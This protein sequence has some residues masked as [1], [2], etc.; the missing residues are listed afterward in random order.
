MMNNNRKYAYFTLNYKRQEV[1]ISIRKPL[2]SVDTAK[3]L[4]LLDISVFSLLT[5]DAMLTL[6]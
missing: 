6:L 1:Y 2:V 3:L 4:E 5:V